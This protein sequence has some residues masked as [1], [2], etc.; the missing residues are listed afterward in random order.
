MYT[1]VVYNFFICIPSF[2]ACTAYTVIIGGAA[3]ATFSLSGLHFVQKSRVF[4]ASLS[5]IVNWFT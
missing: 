2:R 5:A 1:I 4:L 3:A